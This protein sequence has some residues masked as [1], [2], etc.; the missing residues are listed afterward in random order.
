MKEKERGGAFSEQS[1]M[2]HILFIFRQLS[3]LFVH[4][5]LLYLFIELIL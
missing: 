3:S 1:Y 5:C 4:L 2:N